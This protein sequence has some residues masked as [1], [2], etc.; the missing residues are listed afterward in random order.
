MRYVVGPPAVH[1]VASQ[2]HRLLDTG[3]TSGP[4]PPT[5][6]SALSSPERRDTIDTYTVYGPG[7]LVETSHCSNRGGGAYRLQNLSGLTS[8]GLV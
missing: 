5:E 7:T 4:T 8:L 2:S 3:P 1:T 6:Q